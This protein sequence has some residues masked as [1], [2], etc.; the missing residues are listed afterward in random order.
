[1]E[2]RTEPEIAA[3]LGKS[4]HTVHSHLKAIFRLFDVHSRSE[5]I[6]KLLKRE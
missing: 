4:P 6:V 3:L 2:G 5:L 1:V